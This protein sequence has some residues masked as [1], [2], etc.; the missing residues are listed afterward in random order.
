MGKYL[1]NVVQRC[2]PQRATCPNGST[3]SVPNE[4]YARELL[5]LFSLGLWELNQNGT[6]QPERAGPAD[7][8]LHAR[9]RSSSTRGRSPDGPTARPRQPGQLPRRPGAG[10]D[11]WH[12]AAAAI[13]RHR[14]EDAVGRR[15]AAGHAQHHRRALQPTSRRRQQH[16]GAS[17]RRAVHLVAADPL[18]G[19]EQPQPAYI[20]RVAAC[21][22]RRAATCARRSR[23]SSRT[24]R[25]RAFT[26]HRRSAQGSHPAH[27]G[28]R[29][30]ARHS[31]DQSR[32]RAVELQPTS[33]SSC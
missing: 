9:P 13:P 19:D 12:H 23:R 11:C 32:R 20:Q 2:T 33:C 14:A 17:Q 16:H 4:N 29:P 25:P 28:S 7:P 26:E 15:G 8:D 1:D 27:P 10:D 6:V 3:T 22:R 21:S 5:Q 24:P 30:G 18:A 31:C